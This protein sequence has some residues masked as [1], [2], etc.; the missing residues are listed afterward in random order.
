MTFVLGFRREVAT[1][2]H[3]GL[4][5]ADQVDNAEHGLAGINLSKAFCCTRG[6][7]SAPFQG[8]YS[9]HFRGETLE[10]EFIFLSKDT[11]KQEVKLELPCVRSPNSKGQKG[12][13]AAILAY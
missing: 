10:A 12:Q 3:P 8:W 2:S 11:Q 9:P 5:K 13:K 7:V 6:H 4:S 1:L